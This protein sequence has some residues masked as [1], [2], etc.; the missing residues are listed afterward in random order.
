MTRPT[1]KVPGRAE[2]GATC[3]HGPLAGAPKRA[4]VLAAGLGTRLQP[5]T[6][7]CPKPLMTLW[8]VPLIEHALRLLEAWG[9]EEIAVNLHWQPEKIRAYLEG[10][11]GVAQVRCSYEPEILG[12]GG[13][14]RP[15][16]DFL[17]GAPFWVLNADI[18]A[19]LDPDTLLR[20]FEA[21]GGFAAAWL[22]PKKGPRTVEADRRGR[23]TCYRSPTPGVAGTY[24][25]CGL[26]LLSP[27]IY[28]YL[29]D[30]SFCT[31]VD[32]YEQALFAGR[33]VCGVTV[34]GSYWD[35]AGTAEA[36]L[37]IHGDV[38]RCA[39]SGT[40]GGRLYDASADRLDA[41][42]AH[43]F[44]VGREASVDGTVSGRDSVVA[45][46]AVVSAGSSLRG[47]VVVGGTV[48]GA[49]TGAVCVG[50]DQTGDDAISATVAAVG[51]FS[52]GAAAELLGKRGSGRT[53]W[54]LRAGDRSAVMIRYSMERPENGRYA[55]HASLLARAGVP[56]PAVLADLPEVQALALEDW[57]DDS[58]QRR[59]EARPGKAEAW[60]PPVLEALAR[61]H[62][63]GTRAVEAAGEALEPPFDRALYAWEHGLF[64]RELLSKRYGYGA[65]PAEVSHELNRVAERL[66]QA[67]QVVVHRDFQSSN[68]LFR[69][70]RLAFID[71]QGMRYG[72][73]A[74]D[75]AS[76]LYDPYVTLTPL[77]RTR[78]AEQYGGFQPDDP[79][80]VEL[81]HEG[82]VQRLVQALGAYGR[83]AGV[84][85]PGFVKHILPALENLLEASDACGLDAV[86][87]L[88][89]ELI[90]R[91]QSR[92]GA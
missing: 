72:A 71:F 67:R 56:V 48:G 64:E 19:A 6:L 38:K 36:Y 4:L 21:G 74:Y 34:R 49:L 39:K 75:L 23:V 37:R 29:P 66:G 85:Q 28:D 80:A 35:D 73:A 86:G 7:A 69:G 8:D 14:L 27:E 42:D 87:G 41:G 13:A 26:Q 18:A 55:S 79:E 52:D 45:G 2:A 30:R 50:A 3:G 88:A 9:V 82:A 1:A 51:W 15:F 90:A 53:F 40:V 76:L 91:E 57:G 46:Q 33:F 31:L 58:L 5:L 32:A 16:R 92:C 62:R 17:G 24:T 25:F 65:L 22:E 81:F 60:Y 89:E 20:A 10:R 12:T 47:S 54:R 84:G 61:L 68:V 77:L 59:M 44:C 83:L 11:K 43:F 70:A 63:E 78:L